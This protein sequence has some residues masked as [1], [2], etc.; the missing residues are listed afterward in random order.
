VLDVCAV[1]GS[2]LVAAQDGLTEF[3]FVP[4]TLLFVEGVLVDIGLVAESWRFDLSASGVFGDLRE[5]RSIVV[6]EDCPVADRY[7][8]G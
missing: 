2:P 4:H 1:C 3:C 7:D 8:V 6:A 5:T